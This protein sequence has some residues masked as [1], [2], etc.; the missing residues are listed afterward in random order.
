METSN[1]PPGRRTRSGSPGTTI[2][3]QAANVG[4]SLPHRFWYSVPRGDGESFQSLST[5]TISQQ[6]PWVCLP[7]GRDV[8]DVEIFGDPYTSVSIHAHMESGWRQSTR[9]RMQ[10]LT[11]TDWHNM[12]MQGD[13]VTHGSEVFGLAITSDGRIQNAKVWPSFSNIV[14]NICIRL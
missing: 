2:T 5:V 4:F 8:F 10:A 9:V 11:T 6:L 14:P 13:V 7:V 12:S 3:A 1:S